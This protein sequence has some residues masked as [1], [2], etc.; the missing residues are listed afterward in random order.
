MYTV[1][2]LAA[3][4]PHPHHHGGGHHGGGGH[5]GGGRGRG[6]PVPYPVPTYGYGPAYVEGGPYVYLD[7]SPAG[8]SVYIMEGNVWS[9][10]AQ[11]VVPEE[12]DRIAR[13]WRAQGKVVK[14]A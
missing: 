2:G 4:P 14:I 9:P 3:P 6:F 13:T 12:A 7:D 11:N 10:V 5:G 1:F 8:V